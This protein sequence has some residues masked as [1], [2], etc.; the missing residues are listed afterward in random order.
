MFDPR[1]VL[2]FS[3]V[4]SVMGVSPSTVARWTRGPDAL[5]VRRLNLKSR[6]V[7]PDALIAWAATRGLEP[8]QDPKSIARPW[9]RASA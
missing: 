9:P 7:D 8:K 5:P 1:P 4:A 2:T 3:E 6:V